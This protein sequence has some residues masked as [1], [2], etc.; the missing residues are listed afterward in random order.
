MVTTQTNICFLLLGF[1]PTLSFLSLWKKVWKKLNIEKSIFSLLLSFCD[2]VLRDERALKNKNRQWNNSIAQTKLEI[3]NI[4]FFQQRLFHL[5]SNTILKQKLR[6][7]FGKGNFLSDEILW[8]DFDLISV[9]NQIGGD[10]F[11]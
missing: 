7:F 6:Q 4:L 8:T 5:T 10:L 11:Y 1:S 3:K 9:F 2:V